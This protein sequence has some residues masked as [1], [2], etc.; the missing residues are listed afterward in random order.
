MNIRPI[1]FS[2]AMV[3]AL[4]VGAKT[5]T[6]RLVTSPQARVLVGDRLYVREAFAMTGQGMIF[7]ADHVGD[8]LSDGW[9]PNI[10]MPRASSR[11]TLVVEQ[12]RRQRLRDISARDAQSEGLIRVIGPHGEGFGLPHAPMHAK[13]PTN[14]PEASPD[15]ITAFSRLWDGLHTTAGERWIDNPRIVAISFSVLHSNVDNISTRAA[16]YLEREAKP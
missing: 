10:F 12:V 11:M 5:Q 2:D 3:R 13:A 6:R 14:A 4:L 1:L 8:N 7:R 16:A 9:H 15:A